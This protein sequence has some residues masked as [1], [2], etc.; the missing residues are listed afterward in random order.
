M[1]KLGASVPHRLSSQANNP[2]KHHGGV[3]QKFTTRSMK[4]T[5]HLLTVLPITAFLVI[6][7][8]AIGGVAGDN[9]NGELLSGFSLGPEITT[10]EFD[11][12]SRG[13]GKFG[14]KCEVTNDCGFPGSICDAKKKSCQCVPE[15]PATN[16]IDK[17]GKG[18]TKSFL[19]PN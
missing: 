19:L 17:C 11:Y 18:E 4:F 12:A 6:L 8:V 2:R 9:D 3:L 16:H 14:D 10:T 13:N 5:D 7:V 1:R 15:L